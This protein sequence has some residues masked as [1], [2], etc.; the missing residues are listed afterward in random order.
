MLAKSTLS[1]E[2]NVHQVSV[3]PEKRRR[4]VSDLN[5]STREELEI[6]R[7]IHDRLKREE[8]LDPVERETVAYRIAEIMVAA[9]RMFTTTLPRLTN[10]NGE[11]TSPMDEDLAGLQTSFFHLCDL[12]YDFDSAYLLAMGHPPPSQPAETEP[13]E[14]EE[15]LG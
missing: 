6:T 14:E 11:S 7:L 2:K 10:V 9:K 3:L 5:Q 13:D 1:E 4:V 12:M 8:C 15:S